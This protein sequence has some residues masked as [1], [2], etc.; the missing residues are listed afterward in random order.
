M[1]RDAKQSRRLP[2]WVTS[3]A[4]IALGTGIAYGL[5]EVLNVVSALILATVLGVLARNL[6]RLNPE[7]R[8]TV[9]AWTKRLLRSGIVLLGLQL[10]V[11]KLLELRPADLVV[12]TATAAVT[13]TATRW[14][15]R[16]IGMGRDQSLLMATGFS[17]C[18]AS[19]IV[20]MSSATDADDEEVASSVAV[21]TLYGSAAIVAFPLLQD[22]LNLSDQSY[23]IWVG[24]SVHEVAQVVATAAVAGEAAVV[25]ALVAKLGRVTMLAPLV[26]TVGIAHRRKSDVT[27]AERKPPVIPLFVVGFLAMVGVRSLGVVSSGTLDAAHVVSTLLLAAGMFGLGVGV[28][29]P[30]LLRTGGK[31]TLVGALATVI[32]AG[33]AYAG[34]AIA[35]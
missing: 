9:A 31:T 5:S 10:S 29:L 14:L 26:A 12:V 2:N 27:T 6:G 3:L 20:A 32:A 17:I 35:H 13:F 33:T 28:H 23:A 7:T 1:P 19:A 25:I 16:R 18:G 24:A 22:V 30:S 15:A 4:T 21:I 8:A 34:L 11:P